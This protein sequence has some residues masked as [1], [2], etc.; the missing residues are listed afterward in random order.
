MHT[1]IIG[2]SVAAAAGAWLKWS[3]TPVLVA[4]R[5]GRMI[6]RVQG[7]KGAGR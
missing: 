4:N 5:L 3:A 2:A 7:T 6:S 1:C